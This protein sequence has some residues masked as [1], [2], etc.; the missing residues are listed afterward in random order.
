[1][2]KTLLD[3]RLVEEIAKAG[4][5]EPRVFYRPALVLRGSHEME[6]E[7]LLEI[8]SELFLV[9]PR[10]TIR[11]AE[12]L[13]PLM[14]WIKDSKSGDIKAKYELR[15]LSESSKDSPFNPFTTEKVEKLILSR[16]YFECL[17]LHRFSKETG[18]IIH[19]NEHRG[20]GIRRVYGRENN[21]RGLINLVNKKPTASELAIYAVRN[22]VDE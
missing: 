15:P 2:I 6:N 19:G 3:K 12:S 1:M 9:E 17:S 10:G 13:Y 16:D 5:E 21:F 8:W 14:E 4:L 20:Y 11:D 18:I 7:P 22:Y